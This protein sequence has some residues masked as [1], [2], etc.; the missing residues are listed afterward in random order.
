MFVY[1][2]SIMPHSTTTTITVCQLL[3]LGCRGADHQTS[4][5]AAKAPQALCGALCSRVGAAQL[6]ALQCLATIV[7]KART[8]EIS[9]SIICDQS[10]S[11]TVAFFII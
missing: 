2:L 8:V 4:L 9:L 5:V 11:R 7:Y 1:F 3:S 6:S 10:L